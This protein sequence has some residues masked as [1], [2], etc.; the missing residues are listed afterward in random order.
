MLTYRN[1][2]EA[3]AFINARTRPPALHYFGD[4]CAER[5]MF[6]KRTTSG[7]MTIN[8]TLMHYVQDDLRFGGGG[9]QWHWGVSWKGRLHRAHACPW[10]VPA[11][12]F[13]CGHAASASIRQAH[14]RHYKSDLAMT[15]CILLIGG[16]GLI[17]RLV[18]AE[19]ATR[20]DTVVTSIIVTN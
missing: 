8:G 10:C 12:P 17:G 7:N 6:L 13:Q 20:P 11:G 19:L 5:D 16:T 3:I 4:N 14:R 9:G 15:T 18:D 2:D 1:L